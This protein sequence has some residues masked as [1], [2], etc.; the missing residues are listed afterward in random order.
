MR[1][2]NDLHLDAIETLASS[3]LEAGR[4]GQAIPLLEAAIR[5]DPLRERS[6]ELLMVALYRSGRHAEALRNY[7]NLRVQLRDELGLDPSPALQRMRDRV[8]LHD[9]GLVPIDER[10]TEPTSTRNPYKGL[11]PFGESD[12]DDFFGRDGLVER[13]LASVEAG[14]RL[15]ALVGPSGSGK[16][17][18]VAAGLIPRLRSGE[19]EGSDTWRVVSVPVGADPLG[20]VRAAV[21]RVAGSPAKGRSGSGLGLAPQEPGHRVLLVLDQF[22]QLFTVADEARRNAFLKALAQE[23]SDPEDQLTVVLTLRADFY[24]RPL[25]HPEFS[26]VF[27]PGVVHVLPMTA[28]ELEAAVVEPAERVGVK[29]KPALLAELVAESVAGRGSLPLLQYALTGYSSSDPVRC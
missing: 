25:Q 8:L 11:Q 27:V 16:S 2:L 19:V 7:D 13:L 12:A 18:V 29:V 14:Q 20:E 17:S 3:E 24:D 26:A 10:E 6:R 22:E 1:R 15:I 9:P 21:A 28:A 23:L 5:D 4:A